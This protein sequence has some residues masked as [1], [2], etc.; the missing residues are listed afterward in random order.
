[1]TW[2]ASRPGKV[3]EQRI[4]AAG[5]W[6][7]KDLFVETQRITKDGTCS[8]SGMTV[9]KLMD[10]AGKTIGM[11][12]PSATSR[13]NGGEVAGNERVSGHLFNYANARSSSGIRIQDHRFNH[14]S[15]P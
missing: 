10:D 1:M 3:A 12:P 14:A 13:R 8:M 9:T 2:G 7:A 11:P 5:C 15:S 4:S 6:R